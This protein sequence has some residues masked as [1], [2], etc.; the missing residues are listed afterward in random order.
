MLDL[1]DENARQ[2]RKGSVAA[3]I[4]L[5]NENLADSGIRTRAVRENGILQLLCEAES[6]EQLDQPSLVP[7]IKEI[8]ETIGPKNIRRVRINSRIMREQQSLWLEEIHR[9]P[10]NQLLWYEEI[11]LARRNP[12]TNLVSD[13]R[14]PKNKY[15]QQALLKASTAPFERDRRQLQRGIVG[16]IALTAVGLILAWFLYK[17]LVTPENKNPNDSLSVSSQ[18]SNSSNISGNNQINEDD[19]FASAVRIAEQASLD[20]RKAQTRAQWLEI[21]NRWQQASDLMAKVPA[22]DRRYKTAQNRK[23]LYRQHSESA[24]RQLEKRGS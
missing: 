17:F 6:A 3:I 4:Q 7:R 14:E 13:W 1:R 20:G 2:A 12:L 21:A 15:S 5:L 11:T 8:L 22:S 24:L 16:G 10:V 18:N 9:D 23:K 19:P